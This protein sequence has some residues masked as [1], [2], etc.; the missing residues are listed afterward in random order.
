MVIIFYS[1]I[2]EIVM[3]I[4]YEI[5]FFIMVFYRRKVFIGKEYLFFLNEIRIFL[6]KF[7]FYLIFF[8]K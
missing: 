6:R 1:I 3:L 7:E 8:K 2:N 4:Y 5:G